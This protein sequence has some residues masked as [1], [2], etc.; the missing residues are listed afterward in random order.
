MSSPSADPA[1]SCLPDPDALARLVS[2]VTGSMCGATFAP[3]EDSARGQSVCGRM[4]MLPLQGHRDINIVLSS[5]AAGARALGAAMFGCAPE[6]LT[7]AMVD[8]AIAELLNMVAGQL[9]T[10]LKLDASLGLPRPTS[11]AE[12]AEKGGVGFD[13]SVL[14]SSTGIG[15]M[16]LW[17]FE[18]T[19]PAAE[20]G[21]PAK[22]GGMFRSLF[23]KLTSA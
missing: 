2:N 7:H 13:D 17:I 23:R 16:K 21:T 20:P 8:D 14:L 9:H 19:V 3:A 4:V 1:P 22:T 5:D 6:N 15:E 18:R 11:L 10:A 12:M